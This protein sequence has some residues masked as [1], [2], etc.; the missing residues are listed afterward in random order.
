MSSYITVFTISANGL[1]SLIK[2]RDPQT[3]DKVFQHCMIQK[4][5]KV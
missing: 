5:P 1:N 3:D 2:R 4:S